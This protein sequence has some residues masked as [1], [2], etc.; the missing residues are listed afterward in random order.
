MTGTTRVAVTLEQCWHRVPGGVARAALDSVRALLETHPEIEQVGVSARHPRPPGSAWRPAVA[1]RALPLPRVVLYESW[2]RLRWPPVQWAAGAVDVIHATGMAVPPR[3]APL[4][5]TVHDLAFLYDERSGTRHGRR[6]FRRSVE[7]ARREA[8]LVVVPS[9]ATLEDCVAHGFERARLR[10]VPWGIRVIPASPEEVVA[11]RRR[12]HL[13][14]PFVL[15]AGTIEPRKNLPTLLDAFARLDAPGVELVLAGPVGW[16]EDLDARLAR[17]GGR[18]RTLGFVAPAELRALYAA[19][20]VFCFPS[21]REGFGLP[22]LEAMAQGAAVVTSASTATAE[23]LDDAGIL[24][25]PRDPDAIAEAL[26]ELLG[27]PDRRHRLGVAALE[28]ARSFSWARTA[29]A[30]AGAYREVRR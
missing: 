11:I 17:L 4:V 25:E 19:A 7:L 30:L 2:H 13:D 14:R 15:W 27:D 24:V 21:L 1:V 28:R 16:N 29:D 5:V 20:E 18:V 22:V 26:A 3:S 23:V 6:F 10:L 9:Q 12:H 8:D